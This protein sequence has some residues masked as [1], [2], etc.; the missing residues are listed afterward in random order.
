MECREDD[1]FWIIRKLNISKRN[2]DLVG[3]V[4]K[5]KYIKKEDT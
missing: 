1:A 3:K 2:Y 5:T 4:T